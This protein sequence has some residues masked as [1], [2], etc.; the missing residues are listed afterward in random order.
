M[1]NPYS[2]FDYSPQFVFQGN[3]FA[4]NSVNSSKIINGTIT[5]T[6][7]ATGTITDANIAVGT[8]TEAKLSSALQTKLANFNTRL[9]A[10]ENA[11]PSNTGF[12]GNITINHDGSAYQLFISVRADGTERYNDSPVNF[13]TTTFSIGTRLLTLSSYLY[14]SVEVPGDYAI[15]SS[16]FT[17]EGVSFIGYENI[18]GVY[19]EKYSISSTLTNATIVYNVDTYFND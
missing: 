14:M 8:I 6:D 3:G 2:S 13:T 16:G 17:T 15:S 11:P 18:G 5:G 4:A 10:L 1:P 12:N 9:T 7:I 19:Y